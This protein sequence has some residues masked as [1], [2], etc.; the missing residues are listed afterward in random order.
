MI[1][2]GIDK[3]ILSIILHAADTSKAEIARRVGLAAS[4]IGERLRR[5]EDAGAIT[6]Y[7]ARLN[8]AA[9]GYPLLA[10]VFVR[11]LK[12]NTSTDTAARLTTVT[13]AEEVHK[14]AGEDCFLLKIRVRGTEELAD[15]LDAEVN[16]IPS[17]SGVRTTIVLRTM[18]ENPPVSGRKEL[19]PDHP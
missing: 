17:V 2:D 6:G 15:I 1:F 11:E 8:G 18:L 13:G 7:A 10:Y 16:T 5:M 4:A 9:L 19:H 12:P 14:I 3:K